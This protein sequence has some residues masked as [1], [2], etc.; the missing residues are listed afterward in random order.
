MTAHTPDEI[1]RLVR[2]FLAAE[3]DGESEPERDEDLFQSGRMDSLVALHLV[4]WTESTFGF[5]VDVDELNLA[6]FV[7]VAKITDFVADK[8]GETQSV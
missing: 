1:E 8:L 6:S 7:T 2:A 4:T 3:A 5:E